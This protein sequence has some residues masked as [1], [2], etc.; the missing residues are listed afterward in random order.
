MIDTWFIISLSFRLQ[1]QPNYLW[2]NFVT[3]PARD[4]YKYG[5]DMFIFIIW[6]MMMK[7]M[8]MKIALFFLVVLMVVSCNDPNQFLPI[9]PHDDDLLDEDG[10]SDE[11]EEDLT[12]I[13]AT[14]TTN[15]L[16]MLPWTSELDAEWSAAFASSRNSP[17]NDRTL[18]MP[19]NDSYIP[20]TSPSSMTTY[21]HNL[22]FP[23]EIDEV[24][25]PQ[26]LH[27]QNVNN[28][29]LLNISSSPLTDIHSVFNFNHILSHY[30]IWS[31]DSSITSLSSILSIYIPPL[32]HHLMA[33]SNYGGLEIFSFNSSYVNLDI[34]TIEVFILVEMD[35][36]I[37]AILIITYSD[38]TVENQTFSLPPYI[39]VNVIPTFLFYNINYISHQEY[40]FDMSHVTI[41]SHFH[42]TLYI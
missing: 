27:E 28:T 22:L 42:F 13:N 5:V 4:D 26:S 23:D 40:H 38:N 15:E 12:M 39:T 1:L 20:P 32:N 17:N 18:L 30:Y 25:Q 9:R 24:D 14:T 37:S 7:M 2:T 3:T 29:I 8:M 10:E 6:S 33:P 41:S 35:N 34:L 19:Q 21:I 36:T 16:P 31:R 11:E